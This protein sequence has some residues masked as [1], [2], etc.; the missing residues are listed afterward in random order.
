MCLW[1]EWTALLYI[2]GLTGLVISMRVSLSSV[3][4]VFT[5]EP[6]LKGRLLPRETLDSAV[7]EKQA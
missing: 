3:L 1:L 2:V 5:L 4:Y 7:T 6:R